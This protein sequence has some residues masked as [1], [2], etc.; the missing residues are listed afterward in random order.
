MPARGKACNSGACRVYCRHEGR[1]HA[2]R[3][4]EFEP[5]RTEGRHILRHANLGRLA[6]CSLALTLLLTSP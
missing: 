1:R 3:P 5:M 4:A 2:A 6:G